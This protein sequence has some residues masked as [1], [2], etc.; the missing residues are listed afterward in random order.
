MTKRKRT[1]EEEGRSRVEM[2]ETLRETALGVVTTLLRMS[3]A[4]F[5]VVVWSSVEPLERRGE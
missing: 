4:S 3:N 5:E 1:R 2:G